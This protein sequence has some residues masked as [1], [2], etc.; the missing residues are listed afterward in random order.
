MHQIISNAIGC[1]ICGAK[2]GEPCVE[3]GRNGHG[4][5]VDMFRA[6]APFTDRIALEMETRRALLER[7]PGSDFDL[8]WVTEEEIGEDFRLLDFGEKLQVGDEAW[9]LIYPDD[10]DDWHMGW[11]TLEKVDDGM[12]IDEGHVAVRRRIE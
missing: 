12:V 2:A 6:H 9:T 11:L 3:G 8:Y 5:R 10:S 1:D 7:F 4:D